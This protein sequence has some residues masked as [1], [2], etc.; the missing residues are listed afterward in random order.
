VASYICNKT[1]LSN[2]EQ[3]KEK[4]HFKIYVNVQV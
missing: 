1:N 3:T 2:D 4:T